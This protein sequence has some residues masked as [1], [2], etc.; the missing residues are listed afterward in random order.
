MPG[1]LRLNQLHLNSTALVKSIACAGL[2]NRASKIRRNRVKVRFSKIGIVVATSAICSTLL[3]AQSLKDKEYFAKEDKNLS[4][5]MANLN[6]TCGSDI[7][8]KFDW[9]RTPSDR[10]YSA[11]S[12]CNA[13]LGALSHICGRSQLGKDTVKQKIKSLTCSFGPQRTITIKDGAIDYRIN[14]SSSNDVEFAQKYLEDN[15]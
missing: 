8:A 11:S 15:L 13:V 5:Y 1:E 2:P 4:G 7:I 14:Y 12:Y 6:R 10:T 9:S 3:H